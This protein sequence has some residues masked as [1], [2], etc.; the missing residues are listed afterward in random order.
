MHTDQYHNDIYSLLVNTVDKQVELTVIA[1]LYRW[2]TQG[3]RYP[4]S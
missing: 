1:R 3:D 2:R 4:D